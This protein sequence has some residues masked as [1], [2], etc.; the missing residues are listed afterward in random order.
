MLNTLQAIKTLLNEDKIKLVEDSKIIIEET[1]RQ[2]TLRKV[3]IA[4][5]GIHTFSLKLE[6]CGFPGQST[7]STHKPVHR[8]CDA[9]SFCVVEGQPYILC[10]ELKSSE[11]TRHE[12]A[13]QFRSAHCF[14]D[15]LDSLLMHYCEGKSIKDWPKK[16]YVFHNQ[17]RT[18]LAREVSS[19]DIDDHH[20]TPETAKFIAVSDGHK[21]YLRKLLN[22]PV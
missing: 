21:T 1:H 15:Y 11:P 10:F 6:K 18:P 5:V 9:I 16:Y 22:K 8:A 19:K 12:V 13:E 7:F 20:S 3:E 14:L 2:A 4:S 17:S